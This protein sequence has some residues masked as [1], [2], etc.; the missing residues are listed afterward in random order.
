MPVPVSCPQCQAACQVDEQH[1]GKRV[2]C[3]KCGKAFT[4][5][6][7]MDEDILPE[8]DAAEPVDGGPPRLDIG[9]ATSPGRV[10]SRN[11]D[12]YLVLQGAWSNLDRRHEMA[13]LV[14]ADGMGGHEAGD[15]ASGLA[16]Q[17][18]GNALN[19]V[20]AGAV[21]RQIKDPPVAVLAEK[22]KAAL[23]EANRA[24]LS[25]SQK[26][27]ACKGMG[28]TAACVLLW[29]TQA[30]IAHVGDCRVYHFHAGLLTPV[31]E[32]QTLVAR[33]VALGTLS[34]AEALVHPN[35]NEVAQALGRRPELEP[36]SHQLVL[37]RG[38]WLLIACDGLHA[39]VDGPALEAEMTNAP[40]SA[41][42]LAHHLVALANEKGGSD[43]CTVIAVRCV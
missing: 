12:S 25:K 21:S 16:I 4:A 6:L 22:L 33:M 7:P 41:L 39:H 3:Y 36:S 24:V 8:I 15:Q 18:F 23:L 29:D 37:T 32:D 20:L 17:T 27:P 42:Q 26:D 11:E 35:R 34:P 9:S 31:T 30:V 38:D 13:V 10:R 40:P 28:S 43:N 2:K 1:L 19:P 5:E 14:V